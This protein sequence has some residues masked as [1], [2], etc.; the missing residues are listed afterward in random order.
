MPALD[1]ELP[2]LTALLP[3]LMNMALPLTPAPAQAQEMLPL[4]PQ[5][6]TAPPL[7]MNTELLPMLAPA[8]VLLKLQE[9]MA[10]P[11]TTL[12]VL[13]LRPLAQALARSPLTPMLLL[14][15]MRT[16]PGGAVARARESELPGV[17][18]LSAEGAPR[19][20]SLPRRARAAAARPPGRAASSRGSQSSSRGG[21]Q[22]RQA[23]GSSRGVDVDSFPSQSLTGAHTGTPLPSVTLDVASRLRLIQSPFPNSQVLSLQ[24]IFTNSCL[25]KP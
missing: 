15:L 9:S 18:K 12:M 10:P 19:R 2:M 1:P 4:R 7:L 21:Q 25:L 23:R 22:P 11:P 5:E 14:L 6:N 20:T 13:P 3:P 8:Q 16:L 17:A 24:V